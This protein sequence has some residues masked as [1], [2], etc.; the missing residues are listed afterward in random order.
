M[1]NV[2]YDHHLSATGRYFASGREEDFRRHGRINESFPAVR[3]SFSFIFPHILHRRGAVMAGDD[4]I[5]ERTCII[6]YVGSR[7][8]TSEPLC[9]NIRTM[10]ST[11]VGVVNRERRKSASPVCRIRWV[12]ICLS[13]VDKGR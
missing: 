2:D 12:L 10:I 11:C 6:R 5:V 7:P 3:R 1:I 13:I 9:E 8:G 4:T